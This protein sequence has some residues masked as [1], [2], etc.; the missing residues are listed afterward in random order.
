MSIRIQFSRRESLWA[1]RNSTHRSPWGCCATLKAQSLMVL[2]VSYISR[3]MLRRD[4]RRVTRFIGTDGIIRWHFHKRQ[5]HGCT[6]LPVVLDHFSATR[7][8]TH[9]LTAVLAKQ[10]WGERLVKPPRFW[11]NRERKRMSH[12]GIAPNWEFLSTMEKLDSSRNSKNCA[13]MGSAPNNDELTK[14]RCWNHPPET[15][16]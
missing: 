4:R 1:S 5:A 10:H 9:K 13:R 12:G 11:A 14:A 15:G 6:R 16:S 3:Q 7:N 2:A 8:D